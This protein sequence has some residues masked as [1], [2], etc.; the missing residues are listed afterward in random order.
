VEHAQI[1][2]SYGIAS[3][4]FVLTVSALTLASY[5]LEGPLRYALVLGS[6]ESL[7]Y[8]R[9]LAAVL[10][11]GLG[12]L[13]WLRGDATMAPL[14]AVVSVL[15]VHCL[16]GLL[17]LP[18]AFQAL[19]GLK[20]F[21]TFLLGFV[22]APLAMQRP[23]ALLGYAVFALLATALGVTLNA[24]VEFPWLGLSYDSAFGSTVA[25]R[26]WWTAGSGTLRLP[27]FARAS[28][29]AATIVVVALVPLLAARLSVFV[30]LVLLGVAS[31]TIWLTT[32]KGAFT[33][34]GAL[35]AFNTLALVFANVQLVNAALCILTFFCLALPVVAVQLG[36]ASGDVPTWLASFMDRV[37][38][39]WP[40]AFALLDHPYQWVWGRG[41][42]GIGAAQ[43]YGEWARANSADNLMVYVLVAFGACGLAYV[44]VFLWHLMRFLSAREPDDFTASCVRGWT[45]LWLSYGLTGGM[46]DQPVMNL[47]AGLVFG[48]AFGMSELG[49]AALQA[50][51]TLHSGAESPAANGV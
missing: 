32:T 25:S 9:D 18:A 7:L 20:V 46:I 2:R 28:F 17:S 22:L 10:A 14:V 44:G 49:H 6:M 51:F 42:G 26:Q 3:A 19:F 39:M 24:F 16:I 5:V 35:L 40:R 33:G 43:E 34:L 30:K 38:D 45:V 13:A 12:V 48:V 11:V 1:D 29:T 41:L 23:R 15:V 36:A 27:G 8:L 4:R 47:I 50:R 31:G 21:L 37:G